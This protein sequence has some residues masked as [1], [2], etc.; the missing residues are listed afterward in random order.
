VSSM[1]LTLSQ[2]GILNRLRR[3]GPATA[4]SP[5]A[6][7]PADGRRCLREVT[8]A[9]HDLLLERLADAPA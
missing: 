4:A 2:L 8:E 1:G 3:D 9:G 7:D 6:A 5:A